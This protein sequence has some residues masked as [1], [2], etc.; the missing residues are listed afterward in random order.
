MTEPLTD[1]LTE[2]DE[3]ETPDVAMFPEW[4][5]DPEGMIN[6][7]LAEQSASLHFMFYDLRDYGAS[8]FTAAPGYA[9][10]YIRLALRAQSNCRSALDAIARGR[11][12]GRK[13]GAEERS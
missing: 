11:R 10:P 1:P 2:D 13:G 7:M 8:I 6:R 3:P 12:A 4:P 5:D 9:Q